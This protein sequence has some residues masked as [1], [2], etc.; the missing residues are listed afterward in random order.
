MFKSFKWMGWNWI[1]EH[2]HCGAIF[3]SVIFSTGVHCAGCWPAH[4]LHIK[5]TLAPPCTLALPCT[6][7]HWYWHWHCTALALEH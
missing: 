5:I 6:G 1:S 3:V 7:L 2:T 4:W